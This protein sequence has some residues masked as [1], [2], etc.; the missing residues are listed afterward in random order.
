[1]GT[2]EQVH[3]QEGLFLQP[4]HLQLLQR[5]GMQQTE[6]H[7]RLGWPYPFGVIEARMSP[8]ALENRLIRYDRLRVIMPSGVELDVP[9]NTDLPPLDISR[10][11]EASSQPF[12][13]HLALPVWY[14]GRA[15]TVQS[16]EQSDDRVKRIFRV[17]ET[18]LRDENT[19]ENPQ[20]VLVRR[21]NARLILE[22]E[23]HTDLELLP[24]MRISFAVDQEV[25]SPRQDPNFI[26]PCLVL[27]GSPALRD[28][29]RDLANQVDA[30]RKEL[31]VQITRSG[32][33]VETIRGIQ[34]EQ[35]LRLRTLNRFAARLPHLVALSTITP[36]ALYLELRELLAELTS[37]HPDRDQFDV[38]DYDH[39]NPFLAFSE[40][41]QKIRPLLIGGVSARYLQ[42]PFKRD[43]RILTAA[44]ADEH[45]KGP[46]EYFIGI[47][48][49][50]DPIEVEKLVV[51]ADRFKLM[52][53]SKARMRVFGI[54]LAEERHPPLELPS[55]TGLNYFRLLR[56]ENQAMWDMIVA[57]KSIAITWSEIETSDFAITLY[58]TVP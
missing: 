13:I 34:F 7:H 57:E 27:S 22:D 52:A 40:L 18:E 17:A 48:T 11:F 32:F 35:M 44:L 46:N 39:E 53:S 12:V 51:D 56:P 54:K 28:L 43:G 49:K 33:S 36:L 15:N 8:D 41:S 21:Y 31:V 30:R 25:R 6:R 58:M 23:D 47:K 45:V 14:P 55:Q 29:V 4:H 16:S 1:M 9:G 38:A 20:P 5:L 50:Q 19:G 2:N 24:L 3:W 10:A 42:V 37:L 26:P